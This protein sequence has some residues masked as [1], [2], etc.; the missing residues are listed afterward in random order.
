MILSRCSSPRMRRCAPGRS[1]A[2][3]RRLAT[4]LKRISFTRVD[5]PDPDTPVTQ[6]KTPSG[7][8]TSTLQVVLGGPL[9]LH[10]GGWLAPLGRRLDAPRAR[11]ELARRRVG[12][13]HDL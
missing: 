1:F 5:L 12:H 10:I 8:F 9:D 4:A 6:Q 2:R 7:I 13:P 11:Q 3:C